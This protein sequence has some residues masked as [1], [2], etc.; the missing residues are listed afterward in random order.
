M[1]RLLYSLIV[2]FSSLYVFAQGAVAV[3]VAALQQ[4]IEDQNRLLQDQSAQLES[5]TRR[6][7]ALEGQTGVA[8]GPP[9]DVVDSEPD[10]VQADL[11]PQVQART[12]AIEAG[13]ISLEHKSTLRTGK[14]TQ[15]IDEAVVLSENVDIYGSFRTFT[16]MGAGDPTLNDGSSKR[17]ISSPGASTAMRASSGGTPSIRVLDTQATSIAPTMHRYSR[18]MLM[19]DIPSAAGTETVGNG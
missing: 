7:A 11:L 4:L 18:A 12:A 6:V 10:D 5:L 2:I 17:A 1:H 9:P 13:E 8:D 14:E 15:I 19:K 3:D 16:E